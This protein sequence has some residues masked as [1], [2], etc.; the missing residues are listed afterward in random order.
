MYRQVS[1]GRLPSAGQA[2]KVWDSIPGGGERWECVVQPPPEVFNV[3]EDLDTSGLRK[4]TI[5]G[6]YKDNRISETNVEK[7]SGI[8]SIISTD[9]HPKKK[10]RI[11]GA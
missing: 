1:T 7:P 2:G 4:E 8:Q 3:L 11:T 10:Q 5:V 9:Y 6:R